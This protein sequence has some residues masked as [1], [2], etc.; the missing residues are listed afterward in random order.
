MYTSGVIMVILSYD[1]GKAE[2][3]GHWHG[4]HPM[5]LP[6]HAPVVVLQLRCTGVP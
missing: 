5:E 4:V 6:V 2:S 1:G 3:T